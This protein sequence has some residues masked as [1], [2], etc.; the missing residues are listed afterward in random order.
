MST[1]I[2]RK[3]KLVQNIKKVYEYSSSGYNEVI[4]ES[5]VLPD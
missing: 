1:E 5:F 2:T 3:D 4:P